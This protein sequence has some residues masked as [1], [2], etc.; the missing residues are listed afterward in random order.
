M[1]ENTSPKITPISTWEG[2]GGWFGITT[3]LECGA[4]IFL[5]RRDVA[6]DVDPLAIHREWH[7]SGIGAEANH[8]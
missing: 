5:D 7:R 8:E 1:S 4:A 3:C 2:V 6:N